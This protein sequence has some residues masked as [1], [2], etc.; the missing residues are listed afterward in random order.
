MRRYG[1]NPYEGYD[2]LSQPFL[3]RGELPDGIP[4]LARVVT[5]GKEAW[6]LSLVRERKRITMGDVVITWEP[7]QA[8]ALSAVLL[9][10]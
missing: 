9:F 10:G 6:A 1:K 4:P 8:S 7:G 5:V 3:Y 2:S